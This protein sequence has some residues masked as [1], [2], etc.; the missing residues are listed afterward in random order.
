MAITLPVVYNHG[1][2]IVTCA[3][4]TGA[5]L[6]GSSGFGLRDL[7]SAP[8]DVFL[9]SN[10]KN[11]GTGNPVPVAWPPNRQ[12]IEVLLLKRPHTANRNWMPGETVQ[13]L[14]RENSDHE[15]R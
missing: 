10:C 8:N 14:A 7:P 1:R 6:A 2:W 11:N 5:E 9:C 4:C 13:E 12:A 15:V 3:W